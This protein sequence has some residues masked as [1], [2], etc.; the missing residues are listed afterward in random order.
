MMTDTNM[1]NFT[2][3]HKGSPGNEADFI[4]FERVSE[5]ADYLMNRT[6]LRPKIAI[7]CGSGLGKL[8][9][10]CCLLIAV[11]KHFS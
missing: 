2:P 3:R 7:I 11:Y 1:N 8:H 6:K 4:A 10:N 5:S 9:D